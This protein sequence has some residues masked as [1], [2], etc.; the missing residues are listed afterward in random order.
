MTSSISNFV[1]SEQ[2]H[3]QRIFLE[4]GVSEIASNASN[5]FIS[6][7]STASWLQRKISVI[8]RLSNTILAYKT[9]SPDRKEEYSINVGRKEFPLRNRAGVVVYFDILM[10]CKVAKIAKTAPTPDIKKN[11]QVVEDER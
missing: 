7:S 4:K 1:V 2:S 9:F 5:V 6:L 10:M 11:L 3:T 8:S